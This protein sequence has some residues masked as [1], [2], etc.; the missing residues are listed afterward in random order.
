M[1]ICVSMCVCVLQTLIISTREG[2]SPPSLSKA[3]PNVC[4]RSWRCGESERELY[5]LYMSMYVRLSVCLSVA[6]IS[7]C[8]YLCDRH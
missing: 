4:L 6:P 3:P 5:L 8:I 1:S 2:Q 7:L